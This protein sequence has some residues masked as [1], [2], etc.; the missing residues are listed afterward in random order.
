MGTKYIKKE[1]VTITKV[2]EVHVFSE[3]NSKNKT[4]QLVSVLWKLIKKYLLSC[5]GLKGRDNG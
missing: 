2:Q 5:K 1:T 4:E 3:S